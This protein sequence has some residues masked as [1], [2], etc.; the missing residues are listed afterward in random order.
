[1]END[2]GGDCF[3]LVDLHSHKQCSDDPCPAPNAK[4]GKQVAKR[5]AW[6]SSLFSGFG[7]A[8]PSPAEVEEPVERPVPA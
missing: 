5:R 4:P 6:L 8:R 2:G 3:D 1:M 7:C